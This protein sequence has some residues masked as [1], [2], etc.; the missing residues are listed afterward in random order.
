MHE[1]GVPADVVSLALGGPKAGAALVAHRDIAGVAFTGSTATAKRIERALA[2]KDG[3]I[4]P[5]IAETGGQN[6]MVVDSTALLEQVVDDVVASAFHS[7][8]QR[9][10]ALRVLYAQEEIADRLL[11]ML[12]GA[13]RTLTIGDPADPATDVGPVIDSAALQRLEQHLD[14][15]RSRILHQ[16]PLPAHLRGHGARLPYF[17]P[18]LIEVDSIADLDAEHFG[19]IL[20]FTRFAAAN[21]DTALADIQR[22]GYG[23]TLG[24]HSRI[25]HRAEQVMAVVKAGNTYVN[26]D[27]VGAVVGVQP[28]GGEGTLRHRPEGR[29]AALSAA[30]RGGAHRHL[31]HRGHRR[32]RGIVTPSGLN[33][34]DGRS[35]ASGAGRL[36]NHLPAV[37]E[38]SFRG[39]PVA[40]SPA[41]RPRFPTVLTCAA[42]R[43][44]RAMPRVALVT[45]GETHE[46]RTARPAARDATRALRGRGDGGRRGRLPHRG[47]PDRASARGR[48]RPSGNPAP[49]VAARAPSLPE[50]QGGSAGSA[51][52]WT[53]STWTRPPSSA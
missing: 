47:R 4:V 40:R 48:W 36:A 38:S 15:M 13:M 33:G 26:R 12:I 50:A 19:P 42:G 9:C 11:A 28:F 1:C 34:L 10:S 20:H 45:Q 7:T 5:F 37:V 21:L 46:S 35:G 49:H 23:L 14:A 18:T 3:P 2:A 6:A 53:P 29:R 17:A 43:R 27:M 24:V 52:A 30:V 16:C 22:A 8:G 25:H 39:Y 44:Q 51:W 31:E 41:G 32:Q